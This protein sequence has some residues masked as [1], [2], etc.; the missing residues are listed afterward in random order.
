[1]KNKCYIGKIVIHEQLYVTYC[2]DS[3]HFLELLH[4]SSLTDVRKDI[5]EISKELRIPVLTVLT[6]QHLRGGCLI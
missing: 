1:M 5:E 6:V 2:P 3:N 4:I